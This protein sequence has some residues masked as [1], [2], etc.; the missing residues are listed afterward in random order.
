MFVAFAPSAQLGRAI[1]VA[2][3]SARLKSAS[4]Q[5]GAAPRAQRTAETWN[6][7]PSMPAPSQSGWQ[8]HRA[9]TWSSASTPIACLRGLPQEQTSG[10]TP[11]HSPILVAR[12]I[13]FALF[14]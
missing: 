5:Y 13:D 3:R 14:L 8:L 6:L 7:T 2:R 1:R 10:S 4:R 9:A 11:T 12:F